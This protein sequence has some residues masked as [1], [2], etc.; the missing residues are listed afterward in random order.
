MTE[1]LVGTASFGLGGAAASP[2]G[3][4]GYPFTGAELRYFGSKELQAANRW[5]EVA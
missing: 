4:S 2:L 1:S 3:Y 5:L